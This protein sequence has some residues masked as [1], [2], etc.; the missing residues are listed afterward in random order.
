MYLLQLLI[1]IKN[2]KIK[3]IAVPIIFGIV[4]YAFQLN[5]TP[6]FQSH[7]SIVIQWENQDL[8]TKKNAI[9][10]EILE[11]RENFIQVADLQNENDT[12]LRSNVRVVHFESNGIFR[13]HTTTENAHK[14]QAIT[15]SITQNAWT[16]FNHKNLNDSLDKVMILDSAYLPQ[17]AA[18]SKSLFSIL[19]FFIFSFIF[20]LSTV[21]YKEFKN[22]KFKFDEKTNTLLK[23]LFN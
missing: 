6:Y 19:S 23:D 12:F 1:L 5:R 17:L 2:N 20:A 9:F 14:S 15:K 3:L 18:N 10:R 22:G 7:N 11:S 4:G 13:I 8:M 16:L 21:L